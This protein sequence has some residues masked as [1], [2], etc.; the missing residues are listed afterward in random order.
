[1]NR[2]TFLTGAAVLAAG[3][4]LP[5]DAE[6]AHLPSRRMIN[7]YNPHTEERMKALYYA[8]GVYSRN[9]A[10]EFS[11]LL[12]D[13]RMNQTRMMHPYLMDIITVLHLTFRVPEVVIYSGYRTPWTNSHLEGA[14]KNS[15]HMKGL[16]VDVH[17]PGVDTL[18]VARALRSAIPGGVGYYP[19]SK[20]VHFDLGGHRSWVG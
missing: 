12:R 10:L 1:M 2:R 16:A 15:L 3:A 7:I 19:H 6:A 11:H 5:V 20:F 17:L 14:A 8:D 18:A 9:A 4:A 13:W